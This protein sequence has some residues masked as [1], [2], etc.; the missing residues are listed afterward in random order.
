MMML[1]CN[2]G[3]ELQYERYGVAEFKMGSIKCSPGG[4]GCDACL[5]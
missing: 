2:Q 4:D 1:D 3:I 5:H